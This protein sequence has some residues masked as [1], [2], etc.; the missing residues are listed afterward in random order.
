M[1]RNLRNGHCTRHA[2][3]IPMARVDATVNA[4]KT[5]VQMKILRNGN[6]TLGLERNLEKLSQPI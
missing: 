4:A 5:T 6:L 2:R 3:T 1:E